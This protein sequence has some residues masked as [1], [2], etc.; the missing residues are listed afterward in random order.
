MKK[1][2]KFIK[3]FGYSNIVLI[4]TLVVT[5]VVILLNTFTDL[6]PIIDK[7]T[8]ANFSIATILTALTALLTINIQQKSQNSLLTGFKGSGISSMVPEI[9]RIE[10]EEL[11]AQNDSVII[12]NT[13]IYN[14][15]EIIPSI[16]KKLL[17]KEAKI[18]FFI[19]D[20]KSD[21]ARPRGAELGR[22]AEQAIANCKLELSFLIK[23]LTVDQAARVKVFTFD[24]MPKITLFG[25]KKYAFVGFYWPKLNAVHGPHFLID[26]TNGSFSK[27]VWTY[28]DSLET[29][30]ITNDLNG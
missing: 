30:D 2:V 19:L 15:P 20:S 12:M 25:S 9:T 27:M 10:F 14:I 1:L 23:S 6:V 22:D 24:S 16:K 17:E 4:V 11:L 7:N 18:E 29:K 8:L 13:W 3:T 5:S 26:N 21:F 28:F